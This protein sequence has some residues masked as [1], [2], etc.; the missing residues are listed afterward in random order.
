MART[1]ADRSEGRIGLIGLVTL[2]LALLVSQREAAQERR[3]APLLSADVQAPVAQ[4]LGAPLRALEHTLATAEDRRRA[5]EE[6]KALRAELTELRRENDRLAA[7]RWRLGRIEDLKGIRV[8]GEVP[9]QQITARVV[10]DPGSPFVRSFLLGA[11]QVDGVREGYAV[12][13]DSGLV[14]HVV[15]A[16][17]Q[18][19]RVLRLDDLNSRVAVMSERS[20]ARAILAGSNDANP[21][22]RFISDI[23]GWHETDRV[24]TSGDDGRLPQGLPVGTVGADGRV[25]LDYRRQPSDWVIVLP[26]APIADA[27][28]V[29]QLGPEL[30]DGSAEAGA[31]TTADGAG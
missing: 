9:S 13:S 17:R 15:S 18:S 2:A 23:E 8:N 1:K 26:Y 14:G 22:L 11:G 16:G 30:P 31:S 7:M 25:D 27:A 4:T 24:V 5:L 3:S 28:D 20:G 21:E 19:S 10:S 6:N 12:L 29:E